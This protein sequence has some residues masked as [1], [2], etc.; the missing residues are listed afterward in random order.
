MNVQNLKPQACYEITVKDLAS[1]KSTLREIV[2][3]IG[4]GFHP[5][6]MCE[7]YV[8]S[9]ASE[10]IFLNFEAANLDVNLDLISDYLD[11]YDETLELWHEF[12]MITDTEY[13]QR[14]E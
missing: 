1:A 9:V 14:K 11:I 2:K 7:D 13:Q 6:N 5:D 10:P 12:G 8:D 3:F 4:L